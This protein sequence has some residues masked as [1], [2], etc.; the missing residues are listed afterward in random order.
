MNFSATGENPLVF[1][2]DSGRVFLSRGGA[3]PVQLTSDDVVISPLVF[4]GVET[5]GTVPDS[6]KIQFTVTHF[7]KV[8][9]DFESIKYLRL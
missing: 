3:T 7:Q 8:S 9:K 2:I 5:G 4:E 6:A 1:T